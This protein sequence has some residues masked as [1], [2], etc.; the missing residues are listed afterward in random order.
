MPAAPERVYPVATALTLAPV[1]DCELAA[2][3]VRQALAKAGLDIAG[4]V[5]LFLTDGMDARACLRVAARAAQCLQ[6]AGC[7]APGVFTESSSAHHFPAVAAMV[8]PPQVR[9]RPEAL[10]TLLCGV[11]AAPPGGRRFGAALADARSGVWCGG[12]LSAHCDL[13][14]GGRAEVGLARG[15]RLISTPLPVTAAAGLDVLRLRSYPALDVLA[16]EL[17]L[18]FREMP[19]LPL[20]LITAGVI[21]G[22]LEGAWAQGRFRL[23][24]VLAAHAADG[25]V[26]L[27]EAV[28]P[29]EHLFWAVRQPLAA[30]RDLW[31]VLEA[32]ERK[33]PRP[34]FGL[35]FTCT[36]RDATFYGSERDLDLVRERFSGMPLL[37][38]YTDR[39]LSDDQEL[40]HAAVMGVFSAAG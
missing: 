18:E 31:V 27:A 17:P 13:G 34:D 12:R 24:D 21:R 20:G 32:L 3:A 35:M 10:S 16:R 37:G 2:V 30:E 5:L 38:A 40:P 39:V 9:E 36:N 1:A 19:R 7:R 28:S 22:E 8:F 26:T 33:L 25:S 23:L 6:V 29:G 15:V 14:W 11:G 4:R